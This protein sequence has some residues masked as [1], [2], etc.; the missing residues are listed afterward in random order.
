MGTDPA[1]T[2]RARIRSTFVPFP[3]EWESLEKNWKIFADQGTRCRAKEI[4]RLRTHE[5]VLPLTTSPRSRWPDGT[6]GKAQ[7][8]PGR[9]PAW[10][11]S[12]PGLGHPWLGCMQCTG[13]VPD[14]GSTCLGPK[15]RGLACACLAA[16]MAPWGVVC[17]LGVC[18]STL[19]FCG[20]RDLIPRANASWQGH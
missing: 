11:R 12:S 10:R 17:G 16:P 5:H 14:G 8:G 4:Q 13:L 3:P 6:V 19:R 2:P 7:K 15:G 1:W 20:S 9:V 18:P